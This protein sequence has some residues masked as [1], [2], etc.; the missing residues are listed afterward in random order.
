MRDFRQAINL[1]L[2][3]QIDNPLAL[4]RRARTVALR[5]GSLPPRASVRKGAA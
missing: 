4:P 5:V 2:V 3:D 1:R